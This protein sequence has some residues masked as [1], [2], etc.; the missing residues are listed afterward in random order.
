MHPCSLLA[1]QPSQHNQAMLGC[2]PLPA[3]LLHGTRAFTAYTPRMTPTHAARAS[4]CAGQLPALCIPQLSCLVVR[5]S[6][7]QLPIG[8]ENHRADRRRMA[9][10]S[11]CLQSVLLARTAR[12][13]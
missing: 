5:P 11:P 12:G 3:S 2:W 13:R 7:Q 10:R 9:G 4:P 8:A 1:A 6:K